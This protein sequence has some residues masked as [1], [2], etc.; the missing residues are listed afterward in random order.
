MQ[1]FYSASA[2]QQEALKR[3]KR[4]ET[5]GFVPTMGALHSGHTSLFDH[6]R[7]QCDWLVCSIFVNPLQFAPTEDLDLYPS[8]F[9]GDSTKCQAH[10]VDALFCPPKLYHQDHS[11]FLRV[12][13]LSQGLCGGD[14]PRHF[15]G[16]TTV[17]ARLFGI[18]QPDLA[19]FG[20][21]DYQQLA[22]IRRMVRDFAMPIEIIGA[23][24]VREAS[25]LALSSRNR[26]LSPENKKRALTLSKALQEIQRLFKME[27]CRNCTQ[28]KELAGKI[29]DVDQLDYLEIVDSE[30][31]EYLE[32]I[33]TTARALVAGKLGS[34]RLIDNL[35]ISL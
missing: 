18:V 17:I 1:I 29:L 3:K 13:K 16:V 19:V 35:E 25:G 27:N 33:T 31:L 15:E 23:P 22:V 6:A 5:I 11:S 24:L 14:R 21:K 7:T 28:L 8:D 4:G 32:T 34:T 10:G 20:E 2:L 9:E 26:F 12:E 30:S